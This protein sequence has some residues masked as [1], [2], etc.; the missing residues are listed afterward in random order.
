M[1]IICSI[2]A[3][4]AVVA[5]YLLMMT[6]YP[7]CLVIWE[8]SCFSNNALMRSC[9]MV[10]YQRWCCFKPQWN[11]SASRFHC[12]FLSKIWKAKEE[13]LLN[14]VIRLKYFWFV[15]LLAIAFLSGF[16]VLVYPRLQLPTSQEFQLFARSHPFEEYDFTYKNH[17]WFKQPERVSSFSQFFNLTINS[18]NKDKIKA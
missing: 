1:S 17:F 15:L 14:F 13:W 2:F 8:R 16:V 18:G 6:W 7:A 12:S 5:N 4:T 11:L 10:C 3:G 9:F